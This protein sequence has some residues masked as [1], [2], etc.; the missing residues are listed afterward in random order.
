[1]GATIKYDIP[2][3]YL[4]LAL[5][6]GIAEKKERDRN[7][8]LRRWQIRNQEKAQNAE[9]EMRRQ[10][11]LADIRARL[12]AA[13]A[14]LAKARAGGAT[15][16]Q[17]VVRQVIQSPAEERK[18]IQDRALANWQAQTLT[19]QQ[20]RQVMLIDQRIQNLDRQYMEGRLPRN[21]YLNLRDQLDQQKAIATAGSGRPLDQVPKKTPAEAFA[22]ETYF[23]A[24]S[25]IRYGRDRN[26]AW[27]VL[28]K[29][30]D[31]DPE[32]GEK[33][34][35]EEKK[36]PTIADKA[37]ARQL[38]ATELANEMSE[39]NP[40]RYP[41]HEEIVER[42]K[43]IL[44]SWE[45]E[46]EEGKRSE[47]AGQ[48]GQGGQTGQGG[49]G[50][51]GG[52]G[53]ERYGYGEWPELDQWAMGIGVES[54]EVR[55]ATGAVRL[56][57]TSPWENVPVSGQGE[58]GGREEQKRV[59]RA[60]EMMGREGKKG[61]GAKRS[62]EKGK[63]DLGQKK[64]EVAEGK[65]AALRIYA[66]VNSGVKIDDPRIRQIFDALPIEAQ[67]AASSMLV[68]MGVVPRRPRTD[69]KMESWSGIYSLMDRQGWA[70]PGAF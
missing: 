64:I 4:N 1:M 13:N 59:K 56:P 8:R 50:G 46:E 60:E 16:A 39:L 34:K 9:L 20:K 27:R 62:P 42:M 65:E 37:R 6:T 23:D 10:A 55:T 19:P 21:Q 36:G 29:P 17:P 38:A 44:K 25:G 61:V 24:E 58:E 66:L 54:P 30:A 5:Q 40:P 51:Q 35:K 18:V 43:K 32:W 33:S 69:T 41:T 68:N 70:H 48:G 22:E 28:A 52:W 11:Q 3:A 63:V 2:S 31:Y 26:G 49:Q 15:F 14:L 7:Y 12:Q 45:E 57:L 53:E 47:Q 67:K